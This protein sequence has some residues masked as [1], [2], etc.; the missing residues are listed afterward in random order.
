MAV[1]YL[2]Y[3]SISRKAGQ[4]AVAAAAYRATAKLIDAGGKV[5][6]YT[7]KHRAGYTV[8]L[9]GQ[10]V[11]DWVNDR[12]EFWKQVEA[13]EKR[14]DSELAKSII[15]ALPKELATAKGDVSKNMADLVKAWAQKNFVDYGLVADIAIHK[16]HIGRNGKSNDNWHAH[17]LVSTRAVGKDGW[18]DKKDA[19]LNGP[20]RAK[21]LEEARTDWA[22]LVNAEFIR[23][24]RPERISEKK[25]V[26]R[27][28][29][30]A[31][32]AVDLQYQDLLKRKAQLE[33][34]LKKLN[35]PAPK[36]APVPVQP[37]PAQANSQV[38]NSQ[39]KPVPAPA[40][41]PAKPAPKPVQVSPWAVLT[42]AERAGLAAEDITTAKVVYVKYSEFG[43]PKKLS[44]L[45]QANGSEKA[46]NILNACVETQK[47]EAKA[48]RRCGNWA[49]IVQGIEMW[50][51]S[52][53]EVARALREGAQSLIDR[54]KGPKI[55]RQTHEAGLQR[56]R[57]QEDNV[58]GYS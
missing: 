26:S 7:H 6:D 27:E 16:P 11:P 9:H 45:L 21:Y 3:A 48:G 44:G 38:K 22:N 56:V 54:Y 55:A 12:G 31:V 5:H 35:T 10:D 39:A 57:R 20:K 40:V 30:E 41:P 36:P 51:Q 52:M 34:K 8:M 28:E 25:A 49:R 29:L 24:G 4:S 46:R 18:A 37:K 14:S 23:L 13:R 47:A 33:Q 2:N 58:Q 50:A 19:R 1:Y 17:V 42:P 15:L 53:Q 32:L 43:G